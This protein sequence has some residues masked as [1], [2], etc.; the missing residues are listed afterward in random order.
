[1]NEQLEQRVKGLFD[2]LMGNCIAGDCFNSDT[3]GYEREI[4]VNGLLK[5]VF[6]STFRFGT[7]EIV[8][9]NGEKSGQLDIVVEIPT[10]YSLTIS[11]GAPRLYLADG[12]AAVIE[13]KTKLTSQEQTRIA[14]HKEKLDRL[15]RDQSFFLK[16]ATT[17][18]GKR[19]PYFV[20]AFRSDITPEA[21]ELFAKER[22]IDGIFVVESQIFVSGQIGEGDHVESNRKYRW[23]GLASMMY[24]LEILR[25]SIS[26]QYGSIKT[27]FP[28]FMDNQSTTGDGAT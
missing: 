8:D 9:P 25:T 13:V 18:Y 16:V 17:V 6:P 27:F 2:T 4:V 28:Y 15:V 22:G 10:F 5:V 3:K 14:Q 7:G 26:L 19:I 23:E 21:L 20:V 1:M 12:V 24:F 11:E